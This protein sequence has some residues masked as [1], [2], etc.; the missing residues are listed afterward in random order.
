MV[1]SPPLSNRHFFE[2]RG[3][4]IADD[5]AGDQIGKFPFKTIA[6]FDADF[7]FLLGDRQKCPIVFPLL[8]FFLPDWG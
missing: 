6:H 5:A 1:P 4:D 8:S 3:D 2:D 7:A